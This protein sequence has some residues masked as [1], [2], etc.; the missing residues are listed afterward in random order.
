MERK[1][2]NQELINEAP[3][4]KMLLQ[5]RLLDHYPFHIPGHLG[6]RAEDLFVTNGAASEEGAEALLGRG[7]VSLDTTECALSDN[8][9]SPKAGGAVLEAEARAAAY[10]KAGGAL[11]LAGGS[12][13]GLQ[14]MLLHYAGKGGRVLVSGA[15]HKAAVQ[16]AELLDIELYYLDE[17]AETFAPPIPRTVSALRL[18]RFLEEDAKFSAFLCTSPDYY[19]QR[20]PL[21]DY[22]RILRQKGIPFLLDAAH[23]A[24]LQALI[25]A[26]LDMEPPA[27]RAAD[28]A[29]M[30]LHKTLP[31]LTGAALVL[32]RRPDDIR[33]LRQA[34]DIWGS[35][36]PSLLI[37]ASGDLARAYAEKYGAEKVRRL[38][39]ELRALAADLKPGLA[40]MPCPGGDPLR[41]VVD[42]SAFG[43]GFEFEKRLAKQGLVPEMADL[44]RLILIVSPALPEGMLREAARLIN[45]TAEALGAS[46][47]GPRRRADRRLAELY[48]RPRTP[49]RK[50]SFGPGSRSRLLT[51]ETF[52]GGP[53]VLAENL[54]PYPPGVPL[55]EAGE[56]PDAEA[57]ALIFEA[58]EAGLEINGLSRAESGGL[59]LP[60]AEANF[61][62]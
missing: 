13:L 4:V 9:L 49:G 55:F 21:G 34:A 30:S 62:V 32:T 51:A 47:P 28:A 44:C 35:S 23:G 39:R 2:L 29:V 26:G 53:Y 33:P 20:A 45:E 18:E 19:G 8:L 40:L 10:W 22:A 46:D 31:A 61:N 56:K 52:A 15:V 27:A 50:L 54:V 37:A 16:A 36:S 48:G 3:L 25:E 58:A 24:H 57:L 59:L 1:I 12:T 17:P 41:A 38:S 60:A 42:V 11:L 14:A 7:L 43:S 5:A 6:G